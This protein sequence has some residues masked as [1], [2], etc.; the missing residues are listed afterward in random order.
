MCNRADGALTCTRSSAG[1][2]AHVGVRK[3]ASTRALASR[4]A[5]EEQRHVSSSLCD[6]RPPQVGAPVLRPTRD[7]PVRLA[8]ALA[9]PVEA[10]TWTPTLRARV[11]AMSVA[12]VGVGT[13]SLC[14]VC[15]PKA[16]RCA[17]Y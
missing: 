17:C 13:R 8:L 14:F 5:D 2:S 6:R 7:L 15:M 11:D 1:A 9:S 3:Q 12:L 10:S 4:S 16:T